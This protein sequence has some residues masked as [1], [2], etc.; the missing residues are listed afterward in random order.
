[1]QLLFLAFSSLAVLPLEKD[2]CP[3]TLSPARQ[4]IEFNC[5]SGLGFTGNIAIRNAFLTLSSVPVLLAHFLKFRWYLNKYINKL[6]ARQQR[7][8][9]AGSSNIKAFIPGFSSGFCLSRQEFRSGFLFRFSRLKC[10]LQSQKLNRYPE[11]TGLSGKSR[12]KGDVTLI[13]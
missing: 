11:I 12:M 6:K 4:D 1:M 8:R 5:I 13:S 9:D 3:R 7:K 2:T 10:I